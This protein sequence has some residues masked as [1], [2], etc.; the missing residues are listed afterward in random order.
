MH[1]PYNR[2]GWGL[3]KYLVMQTI[4]IHLRHSQGHEVIDGQEI[5]Q[6]A[7]RNHSHSL[8]HIHSIDL[9]SSAEDGTLSCSQVASLD[10]MVLGTSSQ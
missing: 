5:P 9:P 6:G 8:S 7:D 2:L 10:R 1:A 3:Q 4:G